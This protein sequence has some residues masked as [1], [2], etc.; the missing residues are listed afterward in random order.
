MSQNVLI[1]YSHISYGR[2]HIYSHGGRERERG[3]EGHSVERR[4]I[5][6]MRLDRLPRNC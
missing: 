1:T 2:L 5:F 3:I 4:K 6:A